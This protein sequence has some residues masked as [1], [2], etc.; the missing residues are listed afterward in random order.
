[1][2]VNDDAQDEQG[3]P[4]R[5]QETAPALLHR[6]LC[7]VGACVTI[8]LGEV[9]R[10][11]T[12]YEEKIKKDADNDMDHCFL[13]DWQRGGHAGRMGRQIKKAGMVLWLVLA[14]GSRGVGLIVVRGPA[15]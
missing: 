10:S 15:T 2:G 1:M 5:R 9:E 4:R 3:Y 6:T 14:G 13:G 11:V 7:R 12:I 8:T